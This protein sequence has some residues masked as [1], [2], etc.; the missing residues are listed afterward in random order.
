MGY[1]ER[2]TRKKKFECKKR[3]IE[4]ITNDPIY[5]ELSPVSEN[6]KELK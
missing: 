3:L 2:Y 6:A 1:S 4:M 5:Q